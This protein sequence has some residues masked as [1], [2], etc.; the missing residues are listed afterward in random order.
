M[1]V[2]H[3]SVT[4]RYVLFLSIMVSSI[5]AIKLNKMNLSVN[6]RIFL[7]IY[8]YYVYCLIQTKYLLFFY[9]N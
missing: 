6:F 3:L 2:S 5:N 4:D 1:F 9:M 7:K 8:I